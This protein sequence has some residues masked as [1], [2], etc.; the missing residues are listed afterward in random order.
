MKKDNWVYYRKIVSFII[1]LII[2]FSAFAGNGAVNVSAATI[3]SGQ[4]GTSSVTYLGTSKDGKGWKNPHHKNVKQY[5]YTVKIKGKTKAGYCME[6]GKSF[7][8]NHKY[9]AKNPESAK[10]WKNMSSARQRLMALVLYYGYNTGKSAPYG[11]SNDY[12]AAT[13]VLVWEVADKDITLSESGK[14]SK[15]SNSHDNLISGRNY[16]EKN[17]DW[18]KNCISKHVKGASFTKGTSSAAKTYLMKYNYKNKNW[19]VELKDSNK[20]NYLRKHKDTSDGLSVSRSGY[21]YTFKSS[22][23]GSKTAVLEND[24]SA[25][26]SQG[27]L[28]LSASASADQSLILGATDH[29]KFYVKMRA[30]SKGT[31]KIVKTSDDGVVEGFKFKVTCSDNGYS[32][33]HTTNSKGE[34]TLNVYPGE[35]VVTEQ[36][37]DSQKKDGYIQ[38]K[39]KKLTVKEGKTSSVKIHNKKVPEG[40]NVIIQKEN[41]DG[42]I[43]A[44]FKFQLTNA[45]TGEVMECMTDDEGIA[46]FNDLEKGNYTI[47]EVLTEEQKVIFV[48]PENKSVEISEDGQTI[49]VAF[50]NKIR[51]TPVSLKKVSLDGNVSGIEFEI[52][53][54]LSTGEVLE[55]RTVI[56][57]EDGGVD[58]GSLRPG[59]YIIEEKLPDDAGYLEQEPLTFDV[60]G[61]ETDPI[62]LTFENVPTSLYITKVDADTKAFLDGAE[63]GLYDADNCLLIGFKVTQEDEKIILVPTITDSDI[64]SYGDPDV[65]EFGILRGLSIG[66]TYTLKELVS[67]DGYLTCE[68]ITF[69]FEEGMELTVENEKAVIPEESSGEVP[70]T[71]PT[72]PVE[73]IKEDAVAT[74]DD[75]NLLLYLAF[76][77]TAMTVAAVLFVKREKE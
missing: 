75:V 7:V 24:K 14:W 11:N 12:Y 60:T 76:A 48:D 65:N 20:G 28:I 43:A 4:T 34:I 16:A 19:A 77:L 3:T 45:E 63:F 33:V 66:E 61:E 23:S 6:P 17:Y 36:L 49:T 56:T 67:P 42:S 32:Q 64:F 41:D 58:L 5:K 62:E 13:Q 59:K 72:E 69:I 18:I 54:E 38:A 1:S 26:T 47:T 73:K 9:T 37:T 70:E 40:S 71:K 25:G 8:H 51:S 53:G 22:S 44:G 52:S 39:S 15:K 57:G 21:D 10:A 30:E 68:D 29:T 50:V 27:M 35:Y 74:G 55:G 31:G 2:V 46:A